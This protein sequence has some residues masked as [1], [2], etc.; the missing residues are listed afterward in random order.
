[1][2]SSQWSHRGF[3]SNYEWSSLLTVNHRVQ[4]AIHSVLTTRIILN[5][6][7]A[8]S[9]RFDDFSV[10]L[11]LSDTDSRGLPR[12][13]LSFAENPAVLDCNDDHGSDNF[14]SRKW[15]DS[16]ESTTQTGMVSI[17]TTTTISHVALPMTRDARGKRVVGRPDLDDEDDMDSVRASGE[18]V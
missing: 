7:E 1:M 2:G 3:W 9:Q 11:H 14:R 13:R 4:S 5:L 16:G 15:L 8:A 6:R 17:S 12:S 18:W 10:D